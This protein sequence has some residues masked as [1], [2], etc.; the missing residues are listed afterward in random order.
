MRRPLA[1]LT[2]IFPIGTILAATLAG[3]QL[4]AQPKHGA[5]SHP[6]Q[7]QGAS[8]SDKIARGKYLTALGDCVACHTVKN[9]ASFAGGR[10]IQTP[11]GTLLSANITPDQKTGIGDW[12][13][14]Q[15]Y[16][17]L[18]EGIDDDGDHLYPAFPYNYYTRV[19]RADSDAI[20]AYLRTLKP[21]HNALQRNQLPFPF[22]MR[23]LMAV[24]NW[25]FLDKG[26]YKPDASKSAAW[27]RGAYL[28]NGLGHCGAC[29]TPMNIL[30]APKNSQFLQGGMFGNWFAPD[31]TPNRRTGLG[32]W[33]R[34]AVIEFLKTGRNPHAAAAA[35]MG[36][37][38]AFSTSKATTADLKAIAVYLEDQKPSP[39]ASP[40]APDAQQMRKGEAIFIDSCSACHRMHGEGVPRFFPPLRGDANLQQKN[41]TTTLNF[42]LAGVQSTPTDARPTPFSMPAYAWKLNDGQIA[43]V[44]TFIR[45]S[46]GNR[47][48]A[49]SAS[50]VA[51]A[52]KKIVNAGSQYSKPENRGSLRHPTPETFAPPNTDSRDNG[53]AKAGRIVP[54]GPPSAS[55]S[56]AE[57]G[58][59]SHKQPGGRS[60]GGPG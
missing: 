54:G 8:S 31:L 50:D 12:T 23:W 52:R 24:W 46:W 28:V 44:E 39:E 4:L 41:P 10:P 32:S 6:A 34:Q 25:L 55:G 16:R 42:I 57:N 49:V 18:H 33:S 13:S 40:A 48:S 30:G 17:A 37:V 36:E 45:N 29:H 14:E 59:T 60:T 9:G 2:F 5:A 38:V 1:A 51:D 22:R 56:G 19:T 58:G 43:A 21:V 11:F 20:F 26:E 7:A 15:F 35:E 27:N 53:T 3:S 47:A